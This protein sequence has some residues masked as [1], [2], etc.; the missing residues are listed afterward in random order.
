MIEGL[1]KS[2]S[3]FVLGTE[4]ER[5]ARARIAELK[6]EATLRDRKRRSLNKYQAI[7]RRLLLRQI[8]LG[9]GIIALPGLGYLA[10]SPKQNTADTSGRNTLGGAFPDGLPHGVRDFEEMY[11]RYLRGYEMVAPYDTEA[12][13]GLA[14]LKERR[15]PSVSFNGI[16][17]FDLRARTDFHIVTVMADQ[18]Q[19]P[20]L[21]NKM[22]YASFGDLDG[23]PIMVLRTD[24]VSSVWAGAV[25]AHETEHGRQH[26]SNPQRAR[27]SR[28]V[29]AAE[30]EQGAYALEFRVL[31]G[32]TRGRFNQALDQALIYLPI[33]NVFREIPDRQFEGINQLFE[34][35]ST[36]LERMNRRVA[37][38]FALNFRA[39]E[40]NS[41]SPADILKRQVDVVGELI[42]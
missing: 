23:Q 37:F 18:Q 33:S 22:G 13:N 6:S 26:Y 10:L 29:N 20:E 24:P 38:V 19:S 1:L 28:D 15:L 3:R 35:P 36:E 30:G 2:A 16:T 12:Q 5:E 21:V 32:Y 41:G 34:P 25:L 4:K 40:N 27:A 9:V 31:N 11:Q 17:V 14:F 7:T 39:V 8:G 42:H